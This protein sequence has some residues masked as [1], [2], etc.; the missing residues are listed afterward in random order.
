MRVDRVLE[1]TGGTRVAL[2]RVMLPGGDVLVPL[3]GETRARDLG[4]RAAATVH[5]CPYLYFCIYQW[6]G[7]QGLL[8]RMHTCTSH[9]VSTY[10]SSYVNNQTAG[11][12]ARFYD[13]RGRFLSCTRPAFASGTTSLGDE[14]TAIRPC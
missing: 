2:N 3:P 6:P 14:T 1:R 10:F 11:T 8:Q 5:G 4:A 7:F 13:H 9:P 12:R